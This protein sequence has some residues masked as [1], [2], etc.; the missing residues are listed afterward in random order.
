M[1]FGTYLYK[2][3]DR[4][5]CK[6][7]KRTNLHLGLGMKFLPLTLSSI[8]SNLAL[9]EALLEEAEAEQLQE[10][11]LRLWE[12]PTPAV[13]VGR[14]SK[15]DIEVNVPQCETENT[16]I[17]RRCS[18]GTSVVLGPGCLV[19]SCLLSVKLRPQLEN[20]T[21]AHQEV[22][23]HLC[24]A[25]ESIPKLAGKIS[26]EGTCDLVLDNRKFSGNS[27][28]C[29]RNWTLYHGTLLYNF[30]IN[31]I[32][33]LLGYPPREPEYRQKRAHRDF[34]INLGVNRETLSKSIQNSWQAEQLLTDWPEAK[35]IELLESKYLQP[36]WHRGKR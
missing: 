34:L 25:L 12:S 21:L 8:E 17:L 26:W 1:K 11:V 31:D 27:L 14:S 36:E 28:R 10:E 18:G 15:I 6:D 33:R 30:P 20:I 5:D 23:T 2:E 29:K 22:M 4:S 19:Y 32:D 7:R 3:W 35:T 13:I 24:K 16:P 9:D